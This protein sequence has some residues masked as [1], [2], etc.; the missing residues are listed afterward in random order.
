MYFSRLWQLGNYS[1]VQ[2]IPIL[3]L[4]AKFSYLMAIFYLNSELIKIRW[5]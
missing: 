4:H 1:R 3:T 5:S 2:N